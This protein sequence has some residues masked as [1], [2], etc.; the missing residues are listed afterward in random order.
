MIHN[1]DFALIVRVNALDITRKL[2]SDRFVFGR[3]RLQVAPLLID[4]DNP[5]N[6]VGYQAK[7]EVVMHEQQIDPSP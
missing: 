5:S 1:A 6:A 3:K 4:T 7:S 2:L